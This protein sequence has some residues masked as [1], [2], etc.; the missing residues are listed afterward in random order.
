MT[1]RWKTVCAL[2]LLCRP[3]PPAVAAACGLVSAATRSVPALVLSAML[4]LQDPTFFAMISARCWLAFH[5]S[6]YSDAAVAAAAAVNAAAVP[7][8]PTAPARKTAGAVLVLGGT[9]PDKPGEEPTEPTGGWLLNNAQLHLFVVRCLGDPAIDSSDRQAVHAALAAVVAADF[10]AGTSVGTVL[11]LMEQLLSQAATSQFQA[12]H[13][14]A[15]LGLSG[16]PTNGECTFCRR[17]L[18]AMG[19]ALPQGFGRCSKSQ[20][21]KFDFP[22]EARSGNFVVVVPTVTSRTDMPF[23]ALARCMGDKT[24]DTND[25]LRVEPREGRSVAAAMQAA[26]QACARMFA[27]APPVPPAAPPAPVPPA[28]P[29]AYTAVA[30]TAVELYS[31]FMD[32][33]AGTDTQGA[34]AQDVMYWGPA[35][36]FHTDMSL[37]PFV[38]PATCPKFLS[39]LPVGTAVLKRCRRRRWG[40]NGAGDS[41][42][43]S[44]EFVLATQKLKHAAD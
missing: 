33:T 9:T 26:V 18:A 21:G 32:A 22:A 2:L 17:M 1:D 10:V 15:A 43:D 27:A 7:V 44:E 8:A 35:H 13:W 42:T 30:S 25:H 39:A 34:I 6:W 12:G 29:P 36:I 3:A 20:D 40:S 28:A 16:M 11:G 31:T 4:H 24:R 23:I 14:Q 37:L 38:S 19:L 5:S 41:D